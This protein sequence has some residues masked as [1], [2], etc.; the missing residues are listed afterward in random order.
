MFKRSDRLIEYVMQKMMADGDNAIFFR[1]RDQIALQVKNPSTAR[2]DKEVRM[3]NPLFSLLKRLHMLDYESRLLRQIG[4]RDRAPTAILKI[5]TSAVD[6]V[7]S[8]AMQLTGDLA[9]RRR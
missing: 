6:L 8:R 9:S 4:E 7:G 5:I 2:L 1:I 3:K